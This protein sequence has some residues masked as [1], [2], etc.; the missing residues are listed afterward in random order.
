MSGPRLYGAI[1]AGGSKFICAVGDAGGRLLEQT[2]IETRA[3]GE[4]LAQVLEYFQAAERTLGG[5]RAVGIGAFGPLDLR[6]SSATFGFITSTPKPGWR[7]TDLTGFLERGLKR[8]VHIDTDVNAAAL[9]ERRWGAGHGLDSLC[10]V[11][12]GTGIGV[13]ALHHGRAVHGLMHPELGHMRVRRHPEDA[14]FAGFCPFHGDCLEGLA[15]GAA[16]VARTGRSFQEAPHTDLIWSLEADYL[17]QLCATLVLSH[18][19]QRILMGG[20]VMQPKLYGAVQDRMRHWL[21]DYIEAEEL[22]SAQ[23]ICPPGLGAAAGIKGALS[24][25]IAGSTG[26]GSAESN[27]TC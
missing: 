20:G 26:Q 10:Y 7:N 11:T 22:Q 14:D 1:E 5:L 9:G 23:Y 4:T 15:S 25:A 24:L 13:G 27:P 19:P 2:R 18:S 17:G 12:V 3:P 6:P 16:V 21:G 8:P